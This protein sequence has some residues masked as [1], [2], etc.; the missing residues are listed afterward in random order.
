M[1]GFLTV[2]A[3]GVV[4]AQ[5]YRWV[6]EDGVVHYSDRPHEGAEE[7][8]LPQSTRSTRAV[9]A[10]PRPRAYVEEAT[11]SAEEPDAPFNYDV[12]EVDLPASGA[13]ILK[14]PEILAFMFPSGP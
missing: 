11:E 8:V 7:I 4:L 12:V 1:L 2:F 5:A 6:D 14:L 9:A 10:A 13:L 3:T